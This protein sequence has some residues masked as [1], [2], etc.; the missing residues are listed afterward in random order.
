MTVL[1]IIHDRSIFSNSGSAQVVRQDVPSNGSTLPSGRRCR[2]SCIAVRSARA[3]VSRGMRTASN[4]GGL[5]PKV[6]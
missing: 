1:R 4:T 3:A 2:A 6:T 5:S